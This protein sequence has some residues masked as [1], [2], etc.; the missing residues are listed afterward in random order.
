MYK[1][2][3]IAKRAIVLHNPPNAA[4]MVRSFLPRPICAATTL[5]FKVSKPISLVVNALS[6][7]NELP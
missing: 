5:Y 7:G 3:S 1:H 4:E 2:T 6:I